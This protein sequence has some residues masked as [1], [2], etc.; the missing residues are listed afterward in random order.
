MLKENDCLLQAAILRSSTTRSLLRCWPS[1]WTR[2]LSLSTSSHACAQ[3]AW[4]SSRVGVQNTG[5]CQ[6]TCHY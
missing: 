5:V 1:R 6:K 3:F 4:A 2:A